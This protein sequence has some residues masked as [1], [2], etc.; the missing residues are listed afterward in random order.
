MTIV[1][2][3][4]DAA[5]PAAIAACWPKFRDRSS[6]VKRRSRRCWSSMIA[7]EP[8]VLPSFT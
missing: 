6:T 7:S 4:L 3:A 8:S 5:S 1:A 2:S